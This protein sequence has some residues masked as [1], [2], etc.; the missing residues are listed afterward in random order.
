VWVARW[1]RET[2][3]CPAV[4]RITPLRPGTALA[5]WLGLALVALGGAVVGGFRPLLRRGGPDWSDVGVD[6]VTRAGAAVGVTILV[7]SI[8]WVVR[9]RVLRARHLVP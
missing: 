1:Y 6:A 3:P 4:R 7:L 9:D 8:V 2:L 5:V